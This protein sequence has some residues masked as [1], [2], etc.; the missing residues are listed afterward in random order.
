[1]VIIFRGCFLP[2]FGF[3]GFL[4][5]LYTVPILISQIFRLYYLPPYEAWTKLT[6]NHVAGIP[7]E[8]PRWDVGNTRKTRT[9]PRRRE[10]RNPKEKH[11]FLWGNKQGI[12]EMW[13]TSCFQTISLQK[14]DRFSGHFTQIFQSFPYFVFCFLFKNPIFFR[15][16]H[17]PT[18][19]PNQKLPPTQPIREPTKP[20]MPT[21]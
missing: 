8:V 6:K 13:E 2:I 17:S 5:D 18:Y 9:E 1:M 7:R 4:W 15:S 14:K 20:L 21:Y 19:F 16:C 11:T 3:R 10:C 12:R